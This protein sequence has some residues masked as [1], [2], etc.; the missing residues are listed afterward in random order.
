MLSEISQTQKD[1]L[2]YDSTYMRYLVVKFMETEQLVATRD[3]GEKG[4][5]R[6][7]VK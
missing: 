4:E 1:K 5:W 3:L 2:L 7:I 6:V